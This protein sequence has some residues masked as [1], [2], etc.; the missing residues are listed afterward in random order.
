MTP[1]T[2]T[3]PQNTSGKRSIVPG[4]F[5]TSTPAVWQRVLDFGQIAAV[6][7]DVA[8][9]QARRCAVR[10]IEKQL[11]EADGIEALGAEIALSC[12]SDWALSNAR[13]QD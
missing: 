7:C 5:G 3:M 12:P 11:G 6:D 10:A 13:A 2:G 9:D 4:V 1:G 8:S